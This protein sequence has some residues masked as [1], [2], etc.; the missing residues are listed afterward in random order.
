[1]T[2]Q[3]EI[4]VKIT[5][6]RMDLTLNRESLFALLDKYREY[7]VIWVVGPAGSGK[8]SL[9]SSYI[10]QRKIPYLWYKVDE[11][12]ADAANVFFYLRL[13]A[14]T[15]SLRKKFG[16]P[17]F[18]PEYALGLP[19]FTR[20]F[21]E[22][23]FE[24]LGKPLMLV[25]D[26]FQKSA[27]GALPEIIRNALSVV[28]QG[29]T[30]VVISRT[31]PPPQ[32]AR[33]IAN[34][35][36]QIV[37]WEDLKLSF[38]ET[39]LLVKRVHQKD[40]SNSTVHKL[41]KKVDGWIAGLILLSSQ[42]D[43]KKLHPQILQR[44]TPEII[45]DYFA[46]EVFENVPEE[47][48]NFLV[49]TSMLSRITV[50]MAQALT[51][52]S[53]SENILEVVSD[54]DNFFTFK[55]RG[56]SDFYNYHALFREFLIARANK[57]FS[58]EVHT[59]LKSRAATLLE[60][61]GDIENAAALYRQIGD[62]TKFIN[63]ILR[64]TPNLLEQGRHK[65]VEDWITSL[66][67]KAVDSNSWL[68][69]WL[70]SCI[71]PFKPSQSRPI[72]ERALKQ[73]EAHQDPQGIF[74]AL[75]GVF[76]SIIY[77]FDKFDLFDQWIP[78]VEKF[79]HSYPVFPSQQVE[80]L[81]TSDMLYAF[82]LR[83]SNH[84][85][86]SRW[87]NRSLMLIE[88]NLSLRL[89][90]QLLLPL[91]LHRIFSGKLAD[92]RNIIEI[93]DGLISSLNYSKLVEITM[94]DA[95]ALFNWLIADFNACKKFVNKSIDLALNNG[96]HTLS[97][98]LNGHNVARLLSCGENSKADKILKSIKADLSQ[99]GAWNKKYYHYL[100]LWRA[101]IAR[102]LDEAE[103]Q[104]RLALAHGEIAGMPQTMAIA[105]WGRAIVL[106]LEG[107][108]QTAVKMLADALDLCE[109]YD[110]RQVKFGCRATEA[111]FAFDRDYRPAGLNA[112]QRAFSVASQNSYYNTYFW[113]QDDIADLCGR[114]LE[115]GICENHLKKFICRRRLYPP[116]NY[117][118]LVNWPWP[119]RIFTLG[120]LEIQTNGTPLK[121]KSKAP[122]KPLYLLKTVAALGGREVSNDL[123][124]DALWPEL[125]GDAAHSAFTSCLH[126]L[127]KLLDNE[128][129]I[130][131][132]D[133][134]ISFNSKICWLD[135]WPY[136]KLIRQAECLWLDT[137]DKNRSSEAVKLT[138]KMLWLNTMEF[139]CP[140][141]P[142]PG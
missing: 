38:D 25:L 136:E 137:T 129:A 66:P 84:P 122:K 80:A 118:H 87:E 49:A 107:K 50:E 59:K 135:L 101:L 1:M 82:M 96:I 45:F 47:I 16:L 10:E 2:S 13:G 14:K 88:N 39:T 43:I 29:I 123:I 55:H 36:M 106:Q 15:A 41:Y 48:R 18:T 104:S 73:F 63:L 113:R 125:D 112:L 42:T 134:K 139:S 9:V 91:L 7:P 20:R 119:I 26:N 58:A 57:R 23:L 121:F 71:L 54:L 33:A 93:L 140:M 53:E 8:T 44:D 132:Q 130:R 32:M 12:D 19:A 103:A 83:Q 120:R 85:D 141:I 11:T 34:Q 128:Q 115:A 98:F 46:N 17:L 68:L 24:E 62:D 72:F 116:D 77:S 21:F 81:I 74:L 124:L 52:H 65:T 99:M 61:I 138:E 97:L 30:L 22:I 56:N 133:G 31:K 102:D 51:G 89:K 94:G 4:P 75:S 40:L 28:P 114:A 67:D 108:E 69:Y 117:I 100:C 3:I 126:R 78:E 79:C 127:R 27:K 92:A 70:G 110:I 111:R 95:K 60:S 37:G 64:N 86:F 105:C 6:P 90:M 109:I 131:V 5:K 35:K 76:Q 142:V